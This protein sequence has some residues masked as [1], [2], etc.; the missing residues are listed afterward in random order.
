MNRIQKIAW[1]IVL[2]TAVAFVVSLIA[3][4]VAYRH[5]G[6]PKALIG[7]SFM[8]LAGLRGL[9][10]MVIKKDKGSV[11]TDERDLLFQ[12]RAAMAGFGTAYLIFGLASMIPFCV[13]GSGA[14]ISVEWLPAI[15]MAAGI[16]HFLAHSVAILSQYG[17]TG[18]GE[19]P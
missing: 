6:L 3:V 8:G 12:K 11:M 18:K 9:A 17:W 4:G 10:P 16:C 2:S 15:F 13:L 5:V 14:M 19:R 1:A 7:F